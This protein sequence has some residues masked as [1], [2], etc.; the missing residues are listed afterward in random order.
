METKKNGVQA[1]AIQK[2]RLP[3][4]MPTVTRMCWRT[5]RLSRTRI[6]T[7]TNIQKPC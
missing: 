4:D 7:V 2:S 1:E 5:E 3:A 6:R